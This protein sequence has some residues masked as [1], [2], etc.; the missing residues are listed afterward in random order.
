MLGSMNDHKPPESGSAETPVFSV[1]ISPQRSMSPRGVA[2]VLMIT[3]VVSFTVSLPFVMLGAWPIAG[4]FGLDVL[5]LWYAFRLQ[6]QSARA[7]E[8]IV[9]TRPVML[10]RDVSAKGR[11]QEARFNPYWVKLKRDVHAEWGVERLSLQ[12]GR[13]SLEIAR[14]L[15]RGEKADFAAALQSGLNA[16]R[17][18]ALP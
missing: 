12:E 18:A 17:G 4:F 2:L 8:E 13:R 1:R 5:L 11:V 15:G 10:I 14:H 6:A 9:V 16:A 7:Y 3:A